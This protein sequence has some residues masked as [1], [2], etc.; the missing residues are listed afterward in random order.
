MSRLG[1]I[2]SVR[3]PMP[4]PRLHPAAT[5]LACAALLALLLAGCGGGSEE[6]TRPAPAA[7]EFPS[8]KGRTIGELLRDSGAKQTKLVVAPAALVFDKGANRYPFGVFTLSQ[9]Q[10]ENADIAL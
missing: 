5:A 1:R 9:E 10:V 2:G 4:R 3:A 6:T 7:T 8:A